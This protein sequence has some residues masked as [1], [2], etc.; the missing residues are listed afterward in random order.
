MH[1]KKVEKKMALIECTEC[2]GK[3]SE[4]A[5]TC[6]HCGYPLIAKK[7]GGEYQLISIRSGKC[8]QEILMRACAAITWTV[9]ISAAVWF[10]VQTKS[11]QMFLRI[12]CCAAIGGV[13]AIFIGGVIGYIYGIYDV[14]AHL[15]IESIHPAIYPQRAR[16]SNRKAHMQEWG[17]Y[18][19]ED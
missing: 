2:K 11:F 5:E 1:L 13:I 17:E 18:Y 19:P 16:R 10:G 7:T 6:P 14:I 9:G 4:W 8:W 15:Q 12:A 3:V